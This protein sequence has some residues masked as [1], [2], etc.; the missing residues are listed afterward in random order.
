M[1]SERGASPITFSFVLI[2]VVTP[3][4]G[5]AM[6]GAVVFW[7][8]AKLSAAVDAAALAAGRTPTATAS[9]VAGPSVAHAF[10]GSLL[11]TRPA[12]NHPGDIHG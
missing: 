9:T 11:K 10:P 6:D 4:L 5:L 12:K 1:R 7:A 3:M 2:L 8:K